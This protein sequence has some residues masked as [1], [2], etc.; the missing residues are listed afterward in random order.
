MEIDMILDIRGTHG[1]G[2]SY[3]PHQI[4]KEHASASIYLV[5]PEEWSWEPVNGTEKPI[6]QY[7][8][9]FDLA[10]LGSYDRTCG[11]CD[12]ISP[13]AEIVR[14]LEWCHDHFTNVML[15]GIL[16]AHTH[17]RYSELAGRLHDYRFFF[18]NTPLKTCIARVRKR[19]KERG[20]TKPLDPKNIIKDWNCIWKRM[21]DKMRKDG[22]SV[23]ILNWKT[24]YEEIL[25]TLTC[26]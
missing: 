3:I 13:V 7:V 26:L 21:P 5:S 19:R 20:N 18:L 1:S 23:T 2:K 10:I 11:G 12:G 22:R 6:A 9:E 14:R 17:K 4:L 8:P 15:E 25:E 24:A 16:V